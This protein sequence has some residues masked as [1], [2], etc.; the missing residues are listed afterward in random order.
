MPWRWRH[1]PNAC[2]TKE[3]WLASWLR[4]ER[5]LSREERSCFQGNLKRLGYD[6]GVVDGVLGRQTR[7]ALKL[8][9]KS[10]NLPADAFPTASL[11]AHVYKDAAA[12]Q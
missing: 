10:R 3:R 5:G 9:Q 12:T 8:Y 1:W 4:D 7:A 6:P 2:R 11:L